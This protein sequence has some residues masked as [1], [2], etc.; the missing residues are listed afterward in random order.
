MA[1]SLVSGLLAGTS[2][3]AVSNPW[4]A[5][6]PG[7]ELTIE[8]ALSGMEKGSQTTYVRDH[9]KEVA[10]W[11]RS[12][13]G[14][15]GMNKKQETLSLTT[16]KWQ[17]EVDLLAKTGTKQGNLV[18]YLAKEFDKLSRS[19]QKKVASQVQEMGMSILSGMGG[20]VKPRREKFLGFDCDVASAMGVTTY[21]MAN[22]QIVLK[23]SSNIMGMKSSV[24][25]TRVKNGHVPADK[26]KVPEGVSIQYNEAMD[27]AMKDHAKRL[28]QWLKD[29]Q[30]KPMP[31][32]GI[33]VESMQRASVPSQPK[34]A[35]D[36]AMPPPDLGE[37]LKGLGSLFGK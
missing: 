3:Y 17:Y 4:E 36:S 2:V 25:A 15:F 14:M 34:A 11:K 23:T 37:A 1:V 19:D 30:G 21:T 29:P 32:P 35:N 28:I 8:Y 31:L 13:V 18:H 22:S 7:K 27:T 10:T 9:G 24:E 12:S 33:P 16:L 6:L 26:F 20:D 5:K